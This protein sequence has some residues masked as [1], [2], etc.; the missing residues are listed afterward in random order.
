[1]FIIYRVFTMS[2]HFP[3]KQLVMGVLI[4][5]C[6]SVYLKEICLYLFSDRENLFFQ[7]QPEIIMS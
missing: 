2:E 3:N 1:M 4:A 7:F 6:L 5:L